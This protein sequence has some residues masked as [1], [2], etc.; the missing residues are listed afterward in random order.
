MALTSSSLQLFSFFPAPLAALPPPLRRTT[1]VW[2]RP[3][4]DPI[5]GSV[6][7]PGRPWGDAL[8]PE[9]RSYEAVA[10]VFDSDGG[11]LIE[12]VEDAWRSVR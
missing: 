7:G 9:R 6:E 4:A 1:G 5:G 2:L 10:V 12:H 11:A 3:P 8:P